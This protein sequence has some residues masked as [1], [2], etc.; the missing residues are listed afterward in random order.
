MPFTPVL[1]INLPSFNTHYLQVAAQVSSQK[2]AIFSYYP[3]GSFK[4]DK[5]LENIVFGPSLSSPLIHRDSFETKNVQVG[6]GLSYKL[7]KR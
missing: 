4:L 2:D 5:D 3:L 6:D 7:T 1:T